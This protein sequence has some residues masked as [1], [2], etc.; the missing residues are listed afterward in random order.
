MFL[1]GLHVV[2][3]RASPQ[4][5]YRLLTRI[6]RLARQE[7]VRGVYALNR[8]AVSEQTLATL[9]DKVDELHR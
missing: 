1:E 4:V 3:T 7:R 2:A 9:C 6:A 5:A 8:T